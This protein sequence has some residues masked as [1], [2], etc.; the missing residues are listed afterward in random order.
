MPED[1]REEE[2]RG[3]FG[4]SPFYLMVN[5]PIIRRIQKFPSNRNNSINVTVKLGYNFFAG[6]D[7]YK[8]IATL[9]GGLFYA[10]GISIVNYPMQIE[11]LYARHKGSIN[12]D[13]FLLNLTDIKLDISY[14]RIALGLGLRL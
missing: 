11:L 12:I 9:H 3:K 2:I 13:S 6:D 4:F 10:F 1:D 5:W 7:D 8:G 14:S